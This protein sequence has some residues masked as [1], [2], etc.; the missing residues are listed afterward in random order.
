MLWVAISAYSTGCSDGYQLGWN[1]GQS[2]MDLQN[3]KREGVV[4]DPDR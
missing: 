2:F 3:A 1:E 4:L